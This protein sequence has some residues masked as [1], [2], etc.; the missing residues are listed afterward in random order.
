MH[1]VGMLCARIQQ[2]EE[3]KRK[4]GGLIH[5]C[6]TYPAGLTKTSISSAVTVSCVHHTADA[7]PCTQPT[8]VWLPAF[9]LRLLRYLLPACDCVEH[10]TIPPAPLQQ[11]FV[12]MH[13]A[14]DLTRFTEPNLL[15][16]LLLS[17]LVV[18]VTPLE[19]T[20]SSRHACPSDWLALVQCH[21]GEA[22]PATTLPES[23]REVGAADRCSLLSAKKRALLLLLWGLEGRHARRKSARRNLDAIPLLYERVAL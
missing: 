13:D 18:L 5:T 12:L 16:V 23:V 8:H 19:D 11:G 4:N 10:S 7:P 6:P 20:D 2:N 15:V 21:P 22:R 1:I 14:D 9:P 3:S 17:L